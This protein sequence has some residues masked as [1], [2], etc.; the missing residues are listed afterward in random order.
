MF[1]VSITCEFRK[2]VELNLW[3]LEKGSKSWTAKAVCY[4]C[5]GTFVD[6]IS[7]QKTSLELHAISWI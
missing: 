5:F 4:F 6:A 1:F 2:G 3:D 7:L